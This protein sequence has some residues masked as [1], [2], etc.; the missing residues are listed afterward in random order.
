MPVGAVDNAAIDTAGFSV[1]NNIKLLGLQLTADLNSFDNAFIEIREK[2][3]RLILFWERF[4]LSLPGRIAI[5][6][7]LLI[8]Q[9]NYLGCFITPNNEILQSIQVLMD[10][11]VTKNL[12][13]SKE[14]RYLPVDKGGLGLF[15]LTKFLD[16]QRCSWIQ[17]A[18][19]LR[20]DNWRFDLTMLA[21]GNS[22]AL[23]RPCDIDKATHPILFNLVNSYCSFV[24]EFTRINSNFRTVPF[25]DNPAFSRGPNDPR[26][27]NKFFFGVDFYNRHKI[28]LRNL[29]MG[30]CFADDR[31]KSIEEFTL[32]NLPLTP[33]IWMRLQLALVNCNRT[34]F[35]PPLQWPTLPTTLSG[36]HDTVIRGS[37]KFS[38]I[39]QFK[40][41]SCYIINESQSVVTFC[42]LVNLVVP[43]AETVS[44]IYGS[45]SNSFLPNDFREFIYLERN[46]FLKTGTRA[47][48][49]VAN[50]DDRCT[51]CR[52][53]NPDTVVRESFF[54]LFF[55]CPTTC[56]LLRGVTRLGGLIHLP[57]DNSFMEKYWFGSLD[58]KTL[59]SLTIIY[60]IFRFVVWKFKLRR[61]VPTQLYFFDN[62]V[63]CL[64]HIKIIRPL[65]FETILVHFH[66]DVILQALG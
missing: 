66:R 16:A 7:T 58:G 47:A 27:L 8:P 51:F 4:R 34:L 49:Y 36:L 11:F 26:P 29:T 31:F 43:P 60:E 17:R 59:A 24:T 18:R 3:R 37:K 20:I 56:L 1:S 64:R 52:I 57:D 25:V 6:K 19:K 33:V 32:D 46:N 48:N 63:A 61:I 13:I 50:L 10:S 54:H 55:T 15:D 5:L 9:L 21:P 62:F 41:A 23:V 40:S 44:A 12:N 45:W 39:I 53:I 35:N 30:D 22:V 38:K 2:I 65:F 14:R 28:L 42:N